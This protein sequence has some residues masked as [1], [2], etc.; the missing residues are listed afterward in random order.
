MTRG[1][2][3]PPA[4]SVLDVRLFDRVR[5]RF[6]LPDMPVIVADEI[7]RQIDALPD[8][9]DSYSWSA[10]S[11]GVVAPPFKRCFIEA[12]STRTDE[13][14]DLS[15]GR[16]IRVPPGTVFRGV[17]CYDVRALGYETQLVSPQ[18]RQGYLPDG[19]R[20]IVAM[21]GYMYHTD[22]QR[23]RILRTFPGP[24]FVHLDD[25]GLILDDTSRIYFEYSGDDRVLLG[26]PDA[27]QGLLLNFQPMPAASIVNFFPFAMKAISA[28][29]RRCM[30]EQVEPSRQ[31]KRHAERHDRVQLHNF[32]VL[33]VRPTPVGRDVTYADVGQPQPSTERREMNHR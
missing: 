9:D 32:Y 10:D 25:H 22:P 30:V 1:R 24:M 26:P 17:A 14:T 2:S 18:H 5:A 29:H 27:T 31:A 16:P 20:W 15:T 4:N 7:A 23:G 19:T 12:A 28:M 21:F 33:K 13:T 11:Y 3:V 6:G 8:D